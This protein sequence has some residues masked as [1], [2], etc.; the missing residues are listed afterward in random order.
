[1]LNQSFKGLLAVGVVA[2]A[3]SKASLPEDALSALTPPPAVKQI[4][5][6]IEVA[7]T[8]A[9][10]ISDD[11]LA[12]QLIWNRLLLTTSYPKTAYA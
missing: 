7:P 4:D 12:G 9:P 11:S 6:G 1:M 3:T 2:A 5:G 8:E 10:G